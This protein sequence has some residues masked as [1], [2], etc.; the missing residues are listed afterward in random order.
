MLLIARI[1]PQ[2]AS[3]I[4][5][6]TVETPPPHPATPQLFA[7]FHCIIFLLCHFLSLPLECKLHESGHFVSLCHFDS[8]KYVE[9]RA[10]NTD[11][12]FNK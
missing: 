8:T 1:P 11:L 9:Y 3:Q 12:G 6:P 10:S 4:T 5:L 2:E 7:S